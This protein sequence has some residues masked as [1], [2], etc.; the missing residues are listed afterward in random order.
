M[1]Q[2]RPTGNE[3]NKLILNVRKTQLMALA[4]KR[5]EKEADGVEGKT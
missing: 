5:R 3:A 1:S 2:R 4:W